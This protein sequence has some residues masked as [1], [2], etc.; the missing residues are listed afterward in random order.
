MA[1]RMYG[2]ARH[3]H[4]KDQAPRG[5]VEEW[6][7]GQHAAAAAQRQAVH[8]DRRQGCA[9][10][11]PGE[12]S[13]HRLHHQHLAALEAAPLR[14][15][16]GCLH[17]NRIWDWEMLQAITSGQSSAQGHACQ[18]IPDRMEGRRQAVTAH[19]AGI[20]LCV[21]RGRP[22]R[23]T[24]THERWL[25]ASGDQASLACAADP[26]KVSPSTLVAM[27]EQPSTRSSLALGRPVVPEV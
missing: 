23:R 10:S 24:A 14:C 4:S 27:F 3:R 11:S 18:A 1:G 20:V 12:L 9:R 8:A 21:S 16:Q 15:A 19:R 22:A 5:R 13:G 17:G 7:D 25:E 26:V 2:R 6:D